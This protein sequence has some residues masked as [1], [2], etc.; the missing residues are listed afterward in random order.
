MIEF[1]C[2]ATVAN[3]PRANQLTW[4][5]MCEHERERGRPEPM[6]QAFGYTSTD[7]HRRVRFTRLGVRTDE[8]DSG[9]MDLSCTTAYASEAQFERVLALQ[10]GDRV[11]LS[12]VLHHH[13]GFFYPHILRVTKR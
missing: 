2:E 7:E 3:L 8:M 11:K 12:G 4:E 10:P 1:T 13:N 9:R 6:R 5:G